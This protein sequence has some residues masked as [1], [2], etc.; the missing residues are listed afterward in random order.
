MFERSAGPPLFGLIFLAAVAGSVGWAAT[1]D[2][3]PVIERAPPAATASEP[4]AGAAR[5]RAAEFNR[6]SALDR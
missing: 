1:A 2:T 4:P 5:S 6:R 3:D